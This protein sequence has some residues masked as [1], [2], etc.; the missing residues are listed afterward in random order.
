MILH[1][2]IKRMFNAKNLW[3]GIVLI[4][5]IMCYWWFFWPLYEMTVGI[6]TPDELIESGRQFYLFLIGGV[7]AV[8]SILIWKK[9]ILG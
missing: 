6:T 5:V 3:R 7:V 8:P 2:F 4:F 1:I 9:I